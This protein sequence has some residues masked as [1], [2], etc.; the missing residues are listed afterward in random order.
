M[1]FLVS[2]VLVF[3]VLSLVI[4][5]GISSFLAQLSV[6]S[7]YW[8]SPYECGFSA[9]SLSFDSFSFSY[10]CLMVFFVV[11]DLEISLLLNMPEQGVYWGSFV[12]YLTFIGLLSLGFV[13]EVWNGDVRWGY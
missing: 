4:L 1:I 7:C 12:F 2:A 13:I 5:G 8:S 11:F 3:V 10:F 6:A 9:S